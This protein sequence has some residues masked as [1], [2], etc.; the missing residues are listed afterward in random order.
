MSPTQDDD[1]SVLHSDDA[2]SEAAKATRNGDAGGSGLSAAQQEVT[3]ATD[4]DIDAI[5]DFNENV[6]AG[7][8]AA[9]ENVEAVEES[10]QTQTLQQ[11]ERPDSSLDETASIP[12]DTPS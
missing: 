4:E 5:P 12:D 8:G 9:L 6:E 1:G 11:E 3:H 10:E 7:E 2:G